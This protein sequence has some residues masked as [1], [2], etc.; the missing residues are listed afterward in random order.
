MRKLLYK[1]SF[2]NVGLGKTMLSSFRNGPNSWV[3]VFKS[4]KQKQNVFWSQSKLLYHW[5][6]R[7]LFVYRFHNKLYMHFSNF[8]IPT[9]KTKITRT[10]LHLPL[11]LPTIKET[12]IIHTKSTTYISAPSY[13]KSVCVCVCMFIYLWAQTI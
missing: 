10:I 2:S 12:T 6:T 5:L 4:D 13:K 11:T 9:A 7:Q 8:I 3:Q 1:F